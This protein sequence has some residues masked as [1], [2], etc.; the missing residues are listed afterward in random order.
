MF[1]YEARYHML[2]PAPGTDLRRALGAFAKTEGLHAA[3]IATAVGSL[4]DP[5]LRFADRQ[6][7]FR[8]SGRYEIVSLVGTLVAKGLHLHA[9][10]SD[11]NGQMLG[12]HLLDGNLVYTTC[13]IVVGAATQFA[14]MRED[15]PASGYRGL[16]VHQ[17]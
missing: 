13:E 1:S 15:N 7:G 3:W 8:A 11:C 2:R 6:T 10:G 16:V 9:S 17:R 4:T 5:H 14:L 12:G